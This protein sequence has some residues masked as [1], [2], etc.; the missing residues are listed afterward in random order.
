MTCV[1]KDRNKFYTQLFLDQALHVKMLSVCVGS[2]WLGC[3]ETFMGQKP[4]QED[5][6]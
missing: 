5:F 2:I 1:I 3:I 6:V 4:M